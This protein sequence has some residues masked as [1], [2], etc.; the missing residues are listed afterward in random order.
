MF[1]PNMAI[2]LVS[3]YMLVFGILSLIF[4]EG[5]NRSLGV[6][7][8]IYSFVIIQRLSRS[9]LLLYKFT[10]LRINQVLLSSIIILFSLYLVNKKDLS[11]N[12]LA[13]PLT[14]LVM[15]HNYITLKNFSFE[16][17]N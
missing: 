14:I 13:I 5:L 4:L 8:I 11:Y 2:K 12:V 7:M 6:F 3:I 17:N 9:G 10:L 15:I 16:K 1:S